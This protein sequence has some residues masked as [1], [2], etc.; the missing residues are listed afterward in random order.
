MQSEKGPLV[1]GAPTR[2]RPSALSLIDVPSIDR[3]ETPG[4]TRSFSSLSSQSKP[5]WARPL[6]LVRSPWILPL[7]LGDDTRSLSQPE[8]GLQFLA[9]ARIETLLHLLPIHFLTPCTLNI[10]L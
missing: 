5:S 2:K 10:I 1:G 8:Q 9:P 3:S 7:L 6:R 4:S